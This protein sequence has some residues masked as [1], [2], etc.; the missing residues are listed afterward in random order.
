MRES[1]SLDLVYF[2]GDLKTSLLNLPVKIGAFADRIKP[3]EPEPV[4]IP[5][6]NLLIMP[7]QSP[8]TTTTTVAVDSSSGDE[9]ARANDNVSVNTADSDNGNFTQPDE[10]FVLL[11]LVCI[12]FSTCD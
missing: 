12:P 8:I 4:D 9:S 5:F 2:S 11:D 3:V 6:S 1:S 10:P 7:K